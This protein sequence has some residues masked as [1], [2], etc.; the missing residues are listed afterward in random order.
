VCYF[1]PPSVALSVDDRGS[2]LGVVLGGDPAGGKGAKRSEGRSSLPHGVLTVG[3]GDHSDLGASRGQGHN[4]V[5]Q[6][7]GET[8]VHGGATG[9]DDVL[10][11][12]LSDVDIRGLHGLPGEFVDREHRLSVQLRL[13][14]QLGSCHSY[15]AGHSDDALIREGEVLVLGAAGGCFHLLSLVVLGNVA[16]FLLNFTHNFGFGGRGEGLTG[17]E[18]E[19]LEV[20]SEHTTGDIHLLDGVGDVEALEDGD[21]VGNTVTGVDDK[22]SG[23]TSGI[24]GHDG[25]DGN[26]DVFDRESLKHDRDHS[27]SVGLGVARSLSKENTIALLGGNAE[28][29][30]ES[31][32]PHLLHVFPALDDTSGDG[33]LQVEDTLLL[34]SVFTNV[35]R[36]TIDALHG[37]GVLRS[38]N[39][40]REDSSGGFLSGETGLNHTRTVVDDDHWLVLIQRA[41]RELSSFNIPSGHGAPPLVDVSGPRGR[42]R[43][44]A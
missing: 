31:V 26:I 32:V 41:L 11:E 37:L 3:S 36:S 29:I 23:A 7:V 27:L 28:L 2:V 20:V 30:V 42:V 9:E 13:E 14:E 22:T 19:L 10:A 25:L 24:E 1:Y 15:G 44:L 16:K 43:I 12:V 5:L 17:L 38:A 18:K 35:L 6:S 34:H 39:D 4:F 40:G 8:L 21:S 33:V